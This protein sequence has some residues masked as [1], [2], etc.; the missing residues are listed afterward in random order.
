MADK[1]ERGVDALRRR[2]SLWS[3]SHRPRAAAGAVEEAVGGA[4]SEEIKMKNEKLSKLRRALAQLLTPR[5]RFGRLPPT[6]PKASFPASGW[7]PSAPKDSTCLAG[8]VHSAPNAAACSGSL[9]IRS[10]RH[11]PAK[12]G[13]HLRSR[14]PGLPSQEAPFGPECACRLRQ[15]AS[16]GPEGINLPSRIAIF[17]PEFASPLDRVETFGHTGFRLPNCK[18][19]K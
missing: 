13:S 1:D 8:S 5:S 4:A 7:M 3:S 11:Q 2:S 6:T 10:R 18:A 17:G 9:P 12:P 14:R 19:L 16:F 15:A